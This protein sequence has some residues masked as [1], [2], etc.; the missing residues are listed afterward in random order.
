MSASDTELAEM[1]SVIRSLQAQL[2]EREQEAHDLRN[3]NT[4]LQAKVD[5][6][7]GRIER[8]N[9]RIYGSSSERHH[10]DQQ[11]IDLG[12]PVVVAEAETEAETEA[13]TTVTAPPD[14]P[15]ATGASAAATLAATATGTPG[16]GR[17]PRQPGSHPGRRRL[18]DSAEIVET[19]LEVPAA[20]RLDANGQPLPVI[21][22][23]ISDK[24]DYRPGTYLIRRFRRA[25]YGRP[26][27]DAQDR[28]V[29]PMP[30][31]LIPRGQMTDAAVIQTVIEKFA[32][33]LPLYRQVLR[34]E[35]V[36]IHLSRSTLVNHVAAV[37][38]AMEPIVAAIAA[39]VRRAPYLHLDDTPIRV[40]DPGRGH[41]ATGRIWVYRSAEAAVFRFTA[42]RE[43]RH[44]AEFLGGYRGFIV[45]DAYAGHEQLYGPDKA[46]HAACWAHVRR[47]FYEI[48]ERYPCAMAVVD[49]LGRLYEIEHA[50]RSATVTDRQRSREERSRPLITALQQRLEI[51]YA[52]GIPSSDLGKAI[53]YARQR[54][55]ALMR[56]LDHGML[57]IDNNPAENALRPWAIGRKNWLFLGSHAGGE[58]AAIIA[59]IIENCR[60]QGID[61][62][63]YL[64]DTVA[65][66]HTGRTDHDA[67]TP[68]AV[69]TSDD[70]MSA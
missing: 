51:A 15:A 1:R 17:R 20:D 2:A 65:A 24:W 11:H 18:P 40:L 43:G 50:L 19:D 5:A 61:P 59:T 62:A 39:T 60:M 21:G 52:T 45:A 25:I 42:T 49:D 46:T 28:I 47:K 64:L 31:F 3:E 44:P 27:S 9:R 10:P 68:H 48:R 36:G 29:A 4:E 35:R 56:H 26:F 13:T 14:M 63:R 41:T 34:A 23:R 54:W 30:A 53:F 66:L 8:M 55:P 67:L 70:R 58:R 12:M 37:A 6:L 69:A 16:A 7:Q 38:G 32:D 33:H 22:W 57:P